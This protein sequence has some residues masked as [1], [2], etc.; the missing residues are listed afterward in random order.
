MKKEQNIPK[1]LKN[2]LHRSARPPIFRTIV[3]ISFTFII[4]EQPVWKFFFTTTAAGMIG[5]KSKVD[6]QIIIEARANNLTCADI[7]EKRI[8]LSTS[9]TG[10]ACILY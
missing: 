4:K 7:D 5:V 8:L 3:T 1:N 2:K 10:L 9:E 6:T